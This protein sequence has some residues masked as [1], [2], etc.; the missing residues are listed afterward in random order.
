MILLYWTAWGLGFVVGFFA[1]LPVKEKP[2]FPSGFVP[3]NRQAIE[4]IK[5]EQNRQT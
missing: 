3:I 5:L 2:P 4:R 1:P